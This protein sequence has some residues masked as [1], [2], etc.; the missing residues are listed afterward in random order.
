MKIVGSY[1]I[2]VHCGI[3]KTKD[4]QRLKDQDN[5]TYIISRKE[6]PGQ[7]TG[8]TCRTLKI[9]ILE[10]RMKKKYRPTDHMIL[11]KLEFAYAIAPHV[12]SEDYMVT[13]ESLSVDSVH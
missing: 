12:I 4:P 1:G 2:Y 7:Y 9:R 10:Y 5:C 8:Q 11:N 3:D 13:P 6:C